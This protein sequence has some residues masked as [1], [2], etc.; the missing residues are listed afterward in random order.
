VHIFPP[1]R[2]PYPRVEVLARWEASLD[3]IGTR[4][5]VAEADGRLV[6]VAAAAA[7]WLEAL[8]VD[9][10]QWSSGI[11][12]EL[13]D[14]ALEEFRALGATRCHLWVLEENE[15]ARRFYERRGWRQNETTRVVPYPPHPL[16]VGYTRELP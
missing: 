13:H 15:Q 8:Y 5:L 10:D 4:V 14:R 9:P 11:G 12:S 7:E 2:Y 6:G 3:D 16:D 1:E